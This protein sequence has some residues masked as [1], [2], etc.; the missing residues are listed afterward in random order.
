MSLPSATQ[1][2]IHFRSA[3][4]V[5]RLAVEELLA[6]AQLARLDPGAQFG[7]QYT[8]A[9]TGSGKIVGAA[10]VEVYGSEALLRSVVVSSEMRGNGLGRRLTEDR[11]RWAADH[12]ITEVY[13]L[14]TDAD[15]YWKE[16]GFR[17]VE[18]A[19]AP[20][21]VRSSKQWAGGCSS[22]AIAMKKKVEP[23]KGEVCRGC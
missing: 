22:T 2:F 20:S 23:S 10:G 13:L 7:L 11:L 17:V 4:E 9:T 19:D 18:R 14:T 12:G 1:D 8:L 21:G 3:L 16:R 5:D 15:L 6:S